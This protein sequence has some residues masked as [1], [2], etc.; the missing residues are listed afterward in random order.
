MSISSFAINEDVTSLK[1]MDSEAS[2]YS[3]VDTEL[4][5]TEKKK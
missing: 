1:R 4:T 2:E 5:E 3:R